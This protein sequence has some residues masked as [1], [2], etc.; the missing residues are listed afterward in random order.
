MSIKMSIKHKSE[1]IGGSITIRPII[2]DSED[3]IEEHKEEMMRL[4]KIVNDN[5]SNKSDKSKTTR[6]I[7]Q[8]V[9]YILMHCDAVQVET[10]IGLINKNMTK[11]NDIEELM[12]EVINHT[13]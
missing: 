4:G 1:A 10:E 13:K 3:V 7:L 2:I 8:F 11:A 12:E 6:D 9:G 5:S